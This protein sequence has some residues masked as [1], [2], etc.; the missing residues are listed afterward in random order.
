MG[1]N[2]RKNNVKEMS[3][4]EILNITDLIMREND[5]DYFCTNIDV[6]KQF[7]K[8]FSGKPQKVKMLESF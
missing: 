5:I 2:N 1:K 6:I 3:L 4:E 7:I 8:E